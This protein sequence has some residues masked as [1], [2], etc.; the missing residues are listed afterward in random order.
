MKIVVEGMDNTGKTSL[1]EVLSKEFMLP[2]I[3]SPGPVTRNEMNEWLRKVGRMD[4]VICDRHPV[5]SEA[6]YGPAIRGENILG[7]DPKTW[8]KDKYYIIYARPP[9]KAIRGN[10]ESRHQMT[11]VHENFSRLLE[12]Y[13]DLFLTWG[14]AI[15]FD[16]TIDQDYIGIRRF[17]HR[18][19]QHVTLKVDD[20][21]HA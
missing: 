11:G 20:A 18:I 6:I 7:E 14:S 9:M 12:A 13:D 19:N 4:E 2:V 16:W 15:V 3:H 21:E 8:F 1:I 10:F 17:L 5:I